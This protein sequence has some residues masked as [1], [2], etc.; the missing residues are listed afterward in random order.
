MK[1]CVMKKDSYI[2]NTFTVEQKH[3]LTTPTYHSRKEKEHSEKSAFLTL[4]V[5]A[6]C[7]LLGRVEGDR[8]VE[9]TPTGKRRKI[10]KMHL[11]LTRRKPANLPL[12]T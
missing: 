1:I 9:W 4:G 11:K 2:C 10:L 5:H 7:K 6:D 3:Q 8:V 12:M